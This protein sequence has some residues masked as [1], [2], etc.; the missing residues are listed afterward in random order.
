MISI[1]KL[2]TENNLSATPELDE[3]STDLAA[4]ASAKAASKRRYN[5]A[6]AFDDEANKAVDYPGLKAVSTTHIVWR[7]EENGSVRAMINIDDSRLKA[8]VLDSGTAEKSSPVV[9]SA[10]LRLMKTGNRQTA[11]SIAKWCRKYASGLSPEGIDIYD[12]HTWAD[13]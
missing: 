7:P 8:Y 1:V 9:D 6:R 11:R 10:I 4:R 2:L 3:I 5:Q 12:W 13:L